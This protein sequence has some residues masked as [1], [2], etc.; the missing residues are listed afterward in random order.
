MNRVGIRKFLITAITPII[1]AQSSY[2]KFIGAPGAIYIFT[3]VGMEPWGRYFTASIESASLILLLIP[4]LSWLGAFLAIDVMVG[5]LFSHFTLLG[6]V[7]GKDSG[8]LFIK[9]WIVMISSLFQL[10]QSR[11]QIPIIGRLLRQS[12]ELASVYDP[13]VN[14][15]LG[16]HLPIFILASFSCLTLFGIIQQ[17]ISINHMMSIRAGLL[18]SEI[19]AAQMAYFMT[20]INVLISFLLTIMVIRFF[21]KPLHELTFVCQ[22]IARGDMS[23]RSN[24]PLS[25]EFGILAVSMNQM[26]DKIQKNETELKEKTLDIRRLFR[27]VIHDVANP[28]TVIISSCRI[29]KRNSEQLSKNKL[30]KSVQSFG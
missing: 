22:R 7:I 17:I 2:L 12:D 23:I 25:S 18:P 5:A 6:I 11:Y 3:K 13:N 10:Y 30:G 27:V 29:A 8:M 28:L 9:A 1:F 21:E 24:I 20:L 15:K 26:L 14:N 19:S 4:R 16:R